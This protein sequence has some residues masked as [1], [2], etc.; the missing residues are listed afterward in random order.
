MLTS[1]WILQVLCNFFI[2]AKKNMKL[3]IDR[4]DSN[5]K[6]LFVDFSMSALQFRDAARHLKMAIALRADDK[7]SF[8]EVGWR[9]DTAVRVAVGDA[10]WKWARL[11][12]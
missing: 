9:A 1:R 3:W 2:V 7:E 6:R 10:A 8:R 4:D 5:S 12:D 11:P